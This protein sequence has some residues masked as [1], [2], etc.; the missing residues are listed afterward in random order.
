M[1]NAEQRVETPLIQ[2]AETRG[3]P[4]PNT[5][6]GVLRRLKELALE[7]NLV[8]IQTENGIVVSKLL[9]IVEDGI[10]NLKRWAENSGKPWE[11]E[12]SYSYLPREQDGAAFWSGEGVEIGEK[13]LLIFQYTNR[14]V[15]NPSISDEQRIETRVSHDFKRLYSVKFTEVKTFDEIPQVI[16]SIKVSFRNNQLL[17]L[18]FVET[19]QTPSGIGRFYERPLGPVR[20]LRIKFLT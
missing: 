17:G 18:S 9:E 2:Q 6:L 14:A 5:T 10:R 1:P 15:Y 4:Y 19:T 11:G 16:E 7:N 13:S 20:E 8:G 12:V 3:E